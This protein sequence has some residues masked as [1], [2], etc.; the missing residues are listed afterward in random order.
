MSIIKKTILKIRDSWDSF[1]DWKKSKNADF[2]GVISPQ[3]FQFL[4]K[5]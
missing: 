5:H 2:V 4:L 3:S 1:I